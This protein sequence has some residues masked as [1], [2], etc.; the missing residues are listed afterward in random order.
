[1]IQSMVIMSCNVSSAVSGRIFSSS[2]G[3]LSGPGCFPLGMCLILCLKAAL[4]MTWW[5]SVVSSLLVIPE[6]SVKGSGAP[7]CFHG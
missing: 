3:A 1:M 6:S 2:F 7:G 5:S 4:S